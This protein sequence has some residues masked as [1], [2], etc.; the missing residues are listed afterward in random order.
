MAGHSRLSFYSVTSTGRGTRLEGS[1]GF[2]GVSGV[3]L[4]CLEGWAQLELLTGTPTRGHF[5]RAISSNQTQDSRRNCSKRQ[6][7][8]AA[9]LLRPGAHTVPAPH[10]PCVIAQSNHRNL[11]AFEQTETP[12]LNRRSIKEFVAV[13]APPQI[14][15]G[16]GKGAV[17][18]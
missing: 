14:E 15:D 8:E 4:G 12:S 16:S 2:A 18:L 9:S 5:S 6:E 10:L 7:A 11:P 3:L 1:D 17:L 13:F